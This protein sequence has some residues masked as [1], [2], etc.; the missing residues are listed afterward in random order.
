MV[1][2][3]ILEAE[4]DCDKKYVGGIY[5]AFRLKYK[6]EAG[7]YYMAKV[8]DDN[9][10]YVLPWNC[11]EI[12]ESKTFGEQKKITMQDIMRSL[13]IEVGD[14]VCVKANG[15][16]NYLICNDKYDLIQLSGSY[17]GKIPN[18]ILGMI[19]GKYD[20]TVYSKSYECIQ[21]ERR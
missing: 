6:T 7:L 21:T 14:I 1:K 5:D 18:V 13:G 3:K 10:L 16:K 4:S 17:D 11:E 20:Y 19:S 15:C 9:L 8:D 2:I 12:E